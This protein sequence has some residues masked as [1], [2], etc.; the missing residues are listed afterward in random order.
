TWSTL[1]VFILAMIL[2]P[3]CQVKVQKEIDSVVGDLRLPDFE[4][5]ENLHPIRGSPASRL[6]CFPRFPLFDI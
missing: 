2:H 6:F 3:E 1:T 5:R 4:D